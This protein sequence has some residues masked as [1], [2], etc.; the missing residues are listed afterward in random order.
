MHY[1][2]L[3]IGS[4]GR[5]FPGRAGGNHVAHIVRGDPGPLSVDGLKPECSTL[6]ERRAPEIVFLRFAAGSVKSMKLPLGKAVD[7]L[8]LADPESC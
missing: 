3:V 6:I 4:A 8:M 2:G 5:H 1:Q 7:L